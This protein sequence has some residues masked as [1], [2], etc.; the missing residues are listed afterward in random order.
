MNP[1][2]SHITQYADESQCISRLNAYVSWLRREFY[3]C[4]RHSLKLMSSQ[5]NQPTRKLRTA[6]VHRNLEAGNEKLTYMNWKV[7]N[8]RSN[9]RSKPSRV[10]QRSAVEIR[11]RK[12]NSNSP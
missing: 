5:M 4:A 6:C 8:S 11:N 1:L 12:L 10:H 9:R 7:A 2:I 3:T